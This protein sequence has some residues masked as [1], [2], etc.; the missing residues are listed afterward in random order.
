MIRIIKSAV[1]VF[2]ALATGYY[3][4]PKEREVHTRMFCA[5]DRV[6]VEFIE[7]KTVWGVMWLDNNGKPISCREDEEVTEPVRQLVI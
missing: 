5:Y 4:L 3:F 1:I 7:G 2:G 6:F